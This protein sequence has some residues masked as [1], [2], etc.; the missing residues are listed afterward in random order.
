[1]PINPSEEAVREFAQISRIG[2][3]DLQALVADLSDPS[4]LPLFKQSVFTD[5]LSRRFEK[6]DAEVLEKHLLSLAATSRARGYSAEK[7]IDEVR[8]KVGERGW[9]EDDA[10]SWSQIEGELTSLIA[11][12]AICC[13][14]K[15]MSLP[16]E[17]DK[18]LTGAS[19]V[20]DVRPVF[21]GERN[22]VVASLVIQTLR[23]RYYSD[24]KAREIGIALDSEDLEGLID[25]CRNAQLKAES[26]RKLFCESTDI[27]PVIVGKDD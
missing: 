27:P 25:S 6:S 5:L 12:H 26:L 8:P 4:I 23:L 7:C 3:E 21:D 14:E 9:T 2:K 20:S 22:D 24:G 16:Y 15:A 17:Y 18:V 19:I 13:L 10:Q 11:S 1:M